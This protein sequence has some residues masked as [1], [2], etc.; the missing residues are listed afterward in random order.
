M[1]EETRLKVMG[2]QDE[3]TERTE[4]LRGLIER[5]SAPDLTLAEAKDLRGRLSDVL[6]RGNHPAVGERTTSSSVSAPSHDEGDGPRHHL[7]AP[8]N[9]M[10][11]AG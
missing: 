5:L 2:S 9:S 1:P 7:W 3:Q 4:A 8:E 11:A 6:E 10:R